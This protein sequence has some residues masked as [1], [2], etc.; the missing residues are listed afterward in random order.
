VTFRERER[1][2][3][4]GSVRAL[5]GGKRVIPAKGGKREGNAGIADFR[6]A[7]AD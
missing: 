4:W 6:V 1:L 5:A 3:V 7:I 2:F